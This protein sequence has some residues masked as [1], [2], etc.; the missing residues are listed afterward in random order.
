MRAQRGILLL[1]ALLLVLQGHGQQRLGRS[2]EQL[3]PFAN[4]DL[5]GL[6][7]HVLL[8]MD[9]F[10]ADSSMKLINAALPLAGSDPEALY[11]LL[12]YR[13]EVLYYEGLFNAAMR[14]L[15]QCEQLARSIA[16]STLIANALNLKGLLHENI[17]DSRQALP[18]LREALRWFPQQPAARYPVSELHHI[19]GNMG[20]Y[21]TNTGALDS[22]AVH[23]KR[24]L[25]LARSAGSPRAIAVAW[26]SLGNLALMRQQVDSALHCF[27]RSFE[28]ATAASDHDIGVDALVGSAK[29]HAALRDRAQA[30]RALSRA[31][32]YL[33]AHRSGIGLVTQRNFARVASGTLR[34]LGDLEGAL[35]DLG[36]WHRIDSLITARNIQSAL[37][38]QA[39]LI[40]ADNALELERIEKARI[41]EAL[42]HTR[43]TRWILGIGAVL[44]FLGLA[45]V[46]ALNSSRQR[47]RQRLTELELAHE[48]HE[49]EIAALRVREQVGRDLHDDLGVG[50]SGLKLRCEMALL[51]SSG[52]PGDA[53]LREQA[54][55]AEELLASMRH[56]IWAL[57]DDQSEL[58][59][60]VAYT[61]NYA[62]SYLAEH[63]IALS[64][65]AAGPW[66]EQRL[67][68][69]ERR[70]CF[71]LVKEALHN[72]VKH[73]KAS[74]VEL[75]MAWQG[76]LVVEVTDDGVGL[77]DLEA[78][79]GNGL[80][81]MRKRSEGIGGR[82]ELVKVA[83][84]T[85]LRFTLPL[86]ERKFA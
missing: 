31:R 44:A 1:A 46:Y 43:S 47:Q 62:R 37:A 6:M 48:R 42:V 80:R 18:Y 52:Q 72:V 49:R 58:S 34:L 10:H 50:L 25:E 28:V 40:K 3:P 70:N 71:L 67:S 22:A 64:V 85:H 65:A 55:T 29:A 32:A 27:S 30:L 15:E 14:D 51:R 35:T 13:A 74:R 56:I 12:S 21:L 38:T 82:V 45:A 5:H 79:A 83:R 77:Q 69:D 4:G 59:D 11:Y 66:P 24:S 9:A 73:A 17:Q 60:L 75:R 2:I 53:L 54:R 23:L 33:Y 86:A 39:Q 8:Q 81:N 84:G 26:W 57:Q 76:A 7:Q 63:G 36:E 19:H 68:T 41:A 20:S 78:G 61:T 16:D